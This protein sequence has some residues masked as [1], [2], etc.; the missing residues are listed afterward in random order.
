MT[1]KTTKRLPATK[2]FDLYESV[3]WTKNVRNKKQHGELL[4]NVYSHS[5]GVYSAWDDTRLIGV[6]RFITDTYA[7]GI[8]F[9]LVVHPQYQNQGIGS[10]LVKKCMMT[11]PRIQWGTYAES[12]SARLLKKVGFEKSEYQAFSKGLCPV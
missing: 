7:H 5:D 8:I 2:L 6:V 11:H 12:S 9:G 10:T 1:Y 4:S 3:G